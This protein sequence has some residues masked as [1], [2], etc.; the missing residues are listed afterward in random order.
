MKKY[1][2]LFGALL[3]IVI[4]I[5][6]N[7]AYIVDETQQTIITQFGNPVGKPKTEAGL[8]F[9]IPFIQDVHFFEKRLLEWDGDP[10]E[11]PTLKKKLIWVDTFARWRIADPLKF[12]Q[13]VHTEAEGQARLDD[14]IDSITREQISSHL[15]IDVVRNS[16][17]KM[18]MESEELQKEIETSLEPVAIGREEM[19][20]KILALAAKAMPNFGIELVDFRIK[21][22]N[23]IE[24]TREEVYSRMI[25]ERKRIAEKY[26]SEGEGTR[27]EIEGRREKELLRIQ[28][29]AYRQAQEIMGKADA[30]ATQI[31][32]RAYNLDPEFYSFTQTLENY[33][34]T[35][36]QNGKL[37]IST[38]SDFFKYLKSIRGNK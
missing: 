37:I 19:T 7:G 33:R 11:I 31:Y 4:I 13:S 6:V 32:A 16:N 9:K 17:R 29:E 22:V 21:R 30:E 12:Y 27:A 3:F 36:K 26:R 20:R 15:L 25:S 38:D 2:Y 5:L 8:Y 1:I 14:I 23:Y 28:S 18:A 10:N 24:R 35:L 34:N